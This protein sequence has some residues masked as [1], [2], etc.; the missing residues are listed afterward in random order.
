[1]TFNI[2]DILAGPN[3]LHDRVVIGKDSKLEIYGLGFVNDPNKNIYE[4][5]FTQAHEMYKLYIP[6][7]I[8]LEQ[9]ERYIKERNGRY[10][11][12]LCKS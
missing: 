11:N 3:D 12:N 6:D 4:W 5:A 10:K 2:G 9:H 7:Y 8:P 1:M